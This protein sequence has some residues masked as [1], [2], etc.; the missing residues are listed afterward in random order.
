MLLVDISLDIAGA[1]FEI[2]NKGILH[3]DVKLKNSIYIPVTGKVKLCDFGIAQI[4]NSDRITQDGTIVGTP[5]YMSPES[6]NGAEATYSSDIYSFGATV[7]HLATNTPPFVADSQ[8][9]LYH[10]QFDNPPIPIEK[11]RE[12]FSRKWSDL[13]IKRC[14]STVPEERPRSMKYV[15]DAL[16]EIKREIS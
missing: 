7:Y 13:I 1:L 9:E 11:L 12:G 14:L 2:H 8:T 10:K 3:R 5:I 15:L 4:P 6:L 16:G